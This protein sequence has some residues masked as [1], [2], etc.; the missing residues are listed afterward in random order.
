MRR[1]LAIALG[2]GLM[3]SSAFAQ[4]VEAP[5]MGSA[6]E[7][8]DPALAGEQKGLTQVLVLGD[9][10]GGGLGAGLLRL[11]EANG[12]YEVTL[13]FNEESG[14]ARPEVYDWPATLPKILASGSYDVIVVLLGTNDRQMIRSGNARHAFNSP[15]WIAAYHAQMDKLLD[16]L[17]N[18]GAKV[19]WVGLPPMQDPEF[20]AAMQ[21]IAA[22]QRARVEARGMTYL[23]I[24]RALSAPDGSYTDTGPD[25][26]GE[27]KKLRG[28]DGISF[29]KAGNNRM[30][31]LVLEAIENVAA[32]PVE[33]T[34]RADVPPLRTGREDEKARVV[35]LFG[36]RLMMGE[37]FTIRP[38]D[39]TADAL[40]MATAD[41]APDEALKAIR[42]M[43][44]PGSAAEQLF[45]LG[46]A[47]RP[48][49]GRVDDFS[50]PPPS[51]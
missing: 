39:V 47:G 45:K 1:I 50:A 19:Y 13:R 8:N 42:A 34:A 12:N 41:L 5:V 20:D 29:F 3:C 14:L 28:K 40:L 35:P 33:K 6:V 2:F 9:A 16:E 32:E 49:K 44:P 7:E 24:R 30:G 27:V 31:Q 43:A 37:D 23:D 36:Q 10:I 25:D 48:P 21:V 17:A 22:Q 4:A 18:S 46:Q 11:V 15:G 26:T 51:E 38:D